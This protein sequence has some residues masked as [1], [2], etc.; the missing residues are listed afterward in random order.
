[1]KRRGAAAHA[2]KM[3][4]YGRTYIRDTISN[5]GPAPPAT[6]SRSR[7]AGDPGREP[8]L[9]AGASLYA[10]ASTPAAA[11]SRPLRS[12]TDRFS[13]VVYA[14]VRAPTL[15]ECQHRRLRR[16]SGFGLATWSFCRAFLILGKADTS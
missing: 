5:C 13:S 9:A 3:D 2:S 14:T 7:P 16:H 1:M 12:N 11:E 15:S 4:L 8:S 10:A 6:H